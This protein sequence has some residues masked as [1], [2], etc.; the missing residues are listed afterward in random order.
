M[1]VSRSIVVGPVSLAVFAWAA[2]ASS[3]AAQDQQAVTVIGMAEQFCSLGQIGHD[4]G[5]MVNFDTPAGPLF[6]ITELADPQTLTTRAASIAL[7]AEA[8]CNGVHRL[9]ITSDNNGLYR[10]GAEADAPGFGSAVPYRAAVNWADQVHLF[11]ADTA[12]RQ[13]VEEAMMVGHSHMGGLVVEFDISPGATNAGAGVPLLSG[14]YSDI[15]RITV[16]PQ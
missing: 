8:M 12:A 11:T 5:V 10:A 1:S 7:S 3:A 13:M 14:E 6:S 4:G 2:C 16:E 9:V 15:L